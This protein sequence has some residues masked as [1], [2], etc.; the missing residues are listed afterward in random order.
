MIR[1]GMR[2]IIEL[3]RKHQKIRRIL[4]CESPYF[5]HWCMVIMR[6]VLYLCTNTYVSIQ[7]CCNKSHRVQKKIQHK[8]LNKTYAVLSRRPIYRDA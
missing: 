1:I 5:H 7:K 3:I 8:T 4:R 6:T 2:E